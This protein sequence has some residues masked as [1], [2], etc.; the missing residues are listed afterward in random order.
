LTIS[1]EF[2]WWGSPKPINEEIIQKKKGR[3]R[4]AKFIY[5][6]RNTINSM[7]IIFIIVFHALQLVVKPPGRFPDLYLVANN[8]FCF[9]SILFMLV[10]AHLLMH[11]EWRVYK[12]DVDNE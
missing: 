8:G 12:P 4:W 1:G 9:A 6:W 3:T 7:A 2:L 11:E 5:S 10:Y